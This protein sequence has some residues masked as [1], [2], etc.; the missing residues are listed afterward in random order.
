MHGRWAWLVFILVLSACSDPPVTHIRIG[1]ANAPVTLDPRFAT[2]AVSERINRLLYRQLV[3][4]DHQF[5]PVPSLARWDVIS[6]VHYRFTLLNAGRSFTDGTR[7][8]AVDV[9]A[10]YDSI[11]DPQGRSPHRSNLEI[12]QHIQ[13]VNEDVVDFI[14]HKTDPLFPGRLVIGI[15]PAALVQAQ[16]N[17]SRKPV[18]SGAFSFVSWPRSGV[19]HLI[20]RQDGQQ[21]SFEHVADPTV[22]VLKLVRGE[23]DIL[24]NDIPPEMITYLGHQS[25]I[26]VSTGKGSNFSYLGLNMA[27]PVLQDRRV[28]QAI[29][30]AINR[31]AIIKKM[32]RG[33]VRPASALLPPEHWSGYQGGV[34]YT[35]DVRRAIH[36]LK[37]AGYDRQ[38]PLRLAYTTSSDP[39]R[40]RLATIMQYQL[41][42]V[43]IELTIRSYDWG[44]F[45][46]DIKAGNFQLYS[47]SWVGIKSPDIFHYVF[48]SGSLPPAGAN[49]GRYNNPSVDRLID[50]ALASTSRD[51]Q[52]RIFRQV[53]ALL[54]ED[55]PYIPLWFE[56]QM[57]ATRSDIGGYTL[58]VD[59]NYDS[60]TGTRRQTP[61]DMINTANAQY[62]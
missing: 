56:H 17:I 28:R 51:E 60:L 25:D 11:L 36:L 15:V 4:F 9:K 54:A 20:R 14:L 37:Q 24:Q 1:L 30:H 34:H 52:A 5:S 31:E 33:M 40:L 49:R 57:V 22:R 48:H 8:T 41:K 27:D 18:G 44:T 43:G 62:H 16:Q 47:L 39:F 29:A 26:R 38:H 7:L 23:I 2:D 12:I 55:L 45:Y 50:S 10:T 46:G 53:Q 35:Y 58:A 19:L 61:V 3:D 6:P 32:W 13:V 42:Q 59:G 21:F